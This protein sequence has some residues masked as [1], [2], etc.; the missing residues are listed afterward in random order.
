MRIKRNLI[1][2]CLFCLLVPTVAQSQEQKNWE[3][4]L[5]PLY[6]WAININGDLGIRGRTA[7]ASIEF[8]DI[9]DNLQG[10]FTARF[11]MLYKEKF[12]LLIDYNYLDLGKEKASGVGNIEAS[13]TSQILHLG[14]T[15]RFLQG[16]HTWD[17]LAGIRYIYLDSS[18]DLN[19][20]GVRLSGDQ[21]WVDPIVG[22]RYSLAFADKWAL[23]LYGDIGGF[24]VSSDFSWQGLALIDFQP[25]R[26]VA[27]VAGYRAIYADYET[28][29]VNDRFV[30]DATVHGPV[31]GIDIRW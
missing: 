22:A 11:N 16:T 13:F 12:G 18:I 3:F 28:G 1:M 17:A 7:N 27:I 5:A 14:A 25:W 20:A 31:V 29:G 8:N 23:R 6:L 26:N 9:W 15:Y 24:G 21:D 30:Y 4:E 10:V 19:N 2:L